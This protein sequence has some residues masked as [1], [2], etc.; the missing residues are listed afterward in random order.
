MSFIPEEEFKSQAG[1]SMAPMI[2]FLFLMLA[3]FACIA[4]T[5]TA[6]KD[7]DIHLAKESSKEVSSTTS[8]KNLHYAIDIKGICYQIENGKKYPITALETQKQLKSLYQK[9]LLPKD[10]SQTRI[11]LSIDKQ[12]KWDD[13]FKFLLAIREVGF[14]AHPVYESSSSL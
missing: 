8:L 3:F 12:A 2:D 4:V 14:D 11:L 9:G 6:T 1:M 13:I 5:R 10:K 7:M